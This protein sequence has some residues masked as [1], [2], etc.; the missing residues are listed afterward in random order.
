MAIDGRSAPFP[1]DSV[2][3]IA[4]RLGEV[5]NAELAAAGGDAAA[6]AAVLTAWSQV[7]T[8]KAV[9]LL[10][11]DGALAHLELARQAV[12]QLPSA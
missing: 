10:G 2:N 5:F 8:T 9:T 12:E 11:R 1:N 7:L 4:D 3:H 6:V